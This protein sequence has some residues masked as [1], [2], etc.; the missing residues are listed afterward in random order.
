MILGTHNSASYA[1]PTKWWMKLINFTSK[2]QDMT[3][4]EQYEYGVRYFDIRISGDLLDNS[5]KHGIIRYDVSLS[6]ILS[7]LNDKT[8]INKDICYVA[9]N[10]EEY[11]Y[12]IDECSNY[13]ECFREFVNKLQDEYPYLTICG[14]YCKGPWRKILS[15]IENPKLI[16]KYWEFNNYKWSTNKFK[17]LIKNIFHFYPKYWAKKD[18]KKYKKEFIDNQDI[19][20]NTVLMLDFV[21]Y[22]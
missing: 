7:Y 19:P 17:Q 8:K 13:I 9:I 3:I 12:D 11:I 18:N 16:E 6:N 21:Q 20:D 10:L 15:E 5:I 4:E 14:G 1:K 22:D 2:C